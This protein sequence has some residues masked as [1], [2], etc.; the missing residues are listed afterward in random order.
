[1]EGQR[2]VTSA[3][4]WSLASPRGNGNLPDIS[5]TCTWEAFKRSVRASLSESS[6]IWSAM[7]VSLSEA[8]D[9]RELRMTNGRRWRRDRDEID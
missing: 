9:E 3:M 1:M 2:I 7:I 4:S 5:V 6:V 8:G